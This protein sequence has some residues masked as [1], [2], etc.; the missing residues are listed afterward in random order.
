MAWA[1]TRPVLRFMERI[2]TTTAGARVSLRMGMVRPWDS[3]PSRRPLAGQMVGDRLAC[4]GVSVLGAEVLDTVVT[5]I[6]D[7]EAEHE[8]HVEL[9][10]LL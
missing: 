1:T 10:R 9:V 6:R 7:E 4:L 5:V 3:I 2:A 8:V